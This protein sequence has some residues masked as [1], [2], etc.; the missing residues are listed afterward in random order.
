VTWTQAVVVAVLVAGA[1]VSGALHQDQLA[2]VLAGAAAGIVA[3]HVRPPS[4]P[5][6]AQ[7]ANVAPLGLALVGGGLGTLAA[8]G[9]LP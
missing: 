7:L 4:G 6:Q 8:L 3:P 9:A 5:T 2:G 1:V